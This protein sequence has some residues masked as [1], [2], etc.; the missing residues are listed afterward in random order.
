MQYCDVESASQVG[1][2]TIHIE[3]SQ[4]LPN[5]LQLVTQINAMTVSF[6]DGRSPPLLLV[7]NGPW[8]T[9][10][11][12]AILMLFERKQQLNNTNNLMSCLIWW[13]ISNDIIDKSRQYLICW[14]MRFL[15]MRCIS[16]LIDPN[17]KSESLWGKLLLDCFVAS[18]YPACFP[19]QHVQYPPFHHGHK[20]PSDAQLFIPL[21]TNK[22]HHGWSN[23]PTSIHGSDQVAT[24]QLTIAIFFP[25]IYLGGNLEMATYHQGG[26]LKAWCSNLK[27]PVSWWEKKLDVILLRFFV[28]VF[29]SP[30]YQH[31]EVKYDSVACDFWHMIDVYVFFF[32]T[33]S[34]GAAL[35]YHSHLLENSV[36]FLLCT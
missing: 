26:R 32:Q 30:K 35:M 21:A 36:V 4:G 31:K 25:G 27:I 29:W 8:G 22:Q 2:G 10:Q 23:G 33:F 19:P 11:T 3:H 14:F 7:D 24:T 6:L 20:K 17:L 18:P 28:K 13:T 15:Q 5:D 34:N 16:Q 1:L 9:F 12:V